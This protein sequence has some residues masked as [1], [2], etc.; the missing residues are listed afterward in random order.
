MRYVEKS[1]LINIADTLREFNKTSAQFSYPQGFIQALQ[2]I[3]HENFQREYGV[4]SVVN[5]LP[6]VGEND[7][8]KFLRVNEQGNWEACTILNAADDEEGY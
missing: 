6:K 1:D 3:Q 4:I 5:P 8:G 2:N 7:I